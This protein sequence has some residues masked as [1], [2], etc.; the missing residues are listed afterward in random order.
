MPQVQQPDRRRL[1][2]APSAV[3]ELWQRPLGSCLQ[4][5]QRQ[6]SVPEQLAAPPRCCSRCCR[7]THARRRSDRRDHD[8]GR[9]VEV[10]VDAE[11]RAPAL[12]IGNHRAPH[13]RH[14]R[15]LRNRLHQ[16]TPTAEPRVAPGVCTR[17]ASPALAD[18]HDRL[19]KPRTAVDKG[20]KCAWQESNL[21]P[22]APEARA[23][24]PELQALGSQV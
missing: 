23:L 24:S 21:R 6:R 12:A 5:R 4:W 19:T 17:R 1:D 7:R 3:S 14:S 22:R 20:R 15:V 9:L 10:F 2:A 18:R 13:S 16:P 8:L 11:V